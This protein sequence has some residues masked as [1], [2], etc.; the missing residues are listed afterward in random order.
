MI[1]SNVVAY[2]SRTSSVLVYMLVCFSRKWITMFCCIYCYVI[3]FFQ[4]GV[5]VEISNL[6]VLNCRPGQ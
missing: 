4:F 5:V 3:V 2:F 1:S 6:D